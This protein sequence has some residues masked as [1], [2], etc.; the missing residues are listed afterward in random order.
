MNRPWT[1][2][3]FDREVLKLIKSELEKLDEGVNPVEHLRN[4]ELVGKIQSGEHAFQVHVK[5]LSNNLI[6]VAVRDFYT[7]YY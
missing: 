3:Q 2:D 7:N 6:D 1:Y 4:A 5:N